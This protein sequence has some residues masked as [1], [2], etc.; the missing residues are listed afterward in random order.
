MKIIRKTLAV[1]AAVLGILFI[2]LALRA[3]GL[4]LANY[5]DFSGF[6]RAASWSW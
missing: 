5:G 6:D 3:I 2:F 1:V 4:T